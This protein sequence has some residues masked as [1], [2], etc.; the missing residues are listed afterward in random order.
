MTD[1]FKLVTDTLL[2]P[3]GLET[4]DID[5]LMGRLLSQDIDYADLY[6]QYSRQEGWALEDGAVK[7]G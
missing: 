4:S 5:R 7:S 2:V 1:T 3:A 6:F